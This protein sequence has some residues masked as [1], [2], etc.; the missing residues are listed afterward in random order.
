MPLICRA[1]LG[2]SVGLL[3]YAGY[4]GGA[5]T[6]GQG[7]RPSP[8]SGGETGTVFSGIALY[9]GIA[10]WPFIDSTCSSQALP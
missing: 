5:E 10:Y 7:A 3:T 1:A 4:Q 2:T 9:L 6:A 8:R